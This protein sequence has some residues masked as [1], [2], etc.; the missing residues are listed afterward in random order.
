MGREHVRRIQVLSQNLELLQQLQAYATTLTQ[1]NGSAY[2]VSRIERLVAG[3]TPTLIIVDLDT[4]PD[5][6]FEDIKQFRQTGGQ[7]WLAIMSKETSDR[8]VSAMRSGANDYLSAQA[9]VDELKQVIHRAAGGAA[10]EPVRPLGRVI[11]VF[12]NKGGVGTTTVAINMASSL[13]ARAPGAVLL[14]DFVLQHGD[15]ATL[16]DTP[17]AYTITNLVQELERADESY[18]R[19]VFSKHAAGMYVLPAPVSA[20]QAELITA[21][22]I[23]RLLGMLRTVFDT[24]VVDLGNEFND[25]TI[26]A[27]DMADRVVLVT[28]PDLASIRNTRRGLE[29]FERMHYD[30]GKYI[31]VLNRGTAHERLGRETIDTA[32]GRAVQWSIPND[33]QAVVQAVNGGTT[34]RLTSNGKKLAKNIDEFVSVCL[35]AAP[36]S[37]KPAGWLQKMKGKR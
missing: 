25:Q 31:I 17:T 26:A 9:S 3:D 8:L 35:Q 16:L 6:I 30:P 37:A 19:S 11:A 13:A 34:V 12:S 29:M 2:V 27:L 22:H 18:L 20:D 15:V 24:I 33:Y 4:T 7:S 28:L 36:A 14:V 32:L 5:T 23:G 1:T 10:K 21:A